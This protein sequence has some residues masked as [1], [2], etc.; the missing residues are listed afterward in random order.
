MPSQVKL[1]EKLR[2]LIFGGVSKNT[3]SNGKTTWEVYTP[4]HTIGHILG[5]TLYEITESNA[6]LYAKRIMINQKRDFHKAR[7]HGF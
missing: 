1:K 2:G 7:K 5:K 4:L 3:D 6:Y